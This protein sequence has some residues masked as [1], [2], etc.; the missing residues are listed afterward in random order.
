PLEHVPLLWRNFLDGRRLAPPRD[1]NH[2]GH[3]D[4]TAHLGQLALDGPDVERRLLGCAL[5]QRLSL[6]ALLRDV[7][8]YRAEGA[9]EERLAPLARG[10]RR[11]LWRG[12][13][14][15]GTR[16][17]GVSGPNRRIVDRT[18]ARALAV[19]GV[20]APHARIVPLEHRSA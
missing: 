16:A 5:A 13:V 6:R 8:T 1:T 15:D 14:G 4:S 20:P 10:R 17:R 7:A 12:D 19:A 11:S 9:T 2:A 18:P 3:R